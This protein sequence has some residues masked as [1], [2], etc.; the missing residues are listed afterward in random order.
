MEIII[1]CSN[2]SH[3]CLQMAFI[4]K[5]VDSIIHAITSFVIGRTA[6]PSASLY[7]GLIIFIKC[8]CVVSNTTNRVKF[9]SVIDYSCIHR[10]STS[11][12]SAGDAWLRYINNKKWILFRNRWNYFDDISIKARFSYLTYLFQTQ[13]AILIHVYV[14]KLILHRK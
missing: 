10:L 1:T 4:H 3:A 9:F 13:M 2:Y 5:Y 12:T 8:F 14:P 7:W 6:R 11:P